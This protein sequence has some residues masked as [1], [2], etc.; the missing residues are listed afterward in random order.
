MSEVNVRLTQ[1]RH[2]AEG[3][4][5]SSN[6]IQD[7]VQAAGD[8]MD[9]LFALGLSDPDL[10]QRYVSVR[11]QMMEWSGTLAHFADN[12]TD[13]A[14][15]IEMAHRETFAMPGWYGRRRQ[16]DETETVIPVVLPFGAY[17][18]PVNRPIYEALQTKRA[19]LDSRE[20]MLVGLVET[21]QTTQNELTDI[22]HRL[23]SNDPDLDVD[24]IPRVQSMV[25]QIEQLDGQI[26]ALQSEIVVLQGEVDLLTEQL[27][28]VAPAPGADMATI[29]EMQRGSTPI[30]L[31]NNTFD[32]VRHIVDKFNVPADI[33]RDAFTWADNAANFPEYGISTGDVPLEGS[34][35]M[36]SREHSYAD[37][38]YGH[39]MYV[40]KVVNGEVW[41][42]DNYHP[43][44]P[45]RLSSVTSEVGGDNMTYLYFP[46]HT[47]A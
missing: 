27:T 39:V 23:L 2:A 14:D 10:M 13:A 30:W 38:V 44:S 41:V 9:G 12:L 7:S 18:A 24:A 11:G 37:D 6:R 33:A 46:W 28:R 26:V 40:E 43:D 1:L 25:R 16:I 21:R 8:V 35:L 34:V 5:R 29:V 42:T 19:E 15:D 22:R 31:K 36:M 3:L 17:I 45:V 32:C 4:Y 47:S 20:V